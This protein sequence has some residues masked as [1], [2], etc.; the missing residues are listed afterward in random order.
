MAPARAGRVLG[1]GREGDRESPVLAALR[2]PFDAILT[3][4]ASAPQRAIPLGV[5]ALGVV[6]L[7]GFAAS[8]PTGEGIPTFRERDILINLDAAPGT[9]EGA[10]ARNRELMGA[11]NPQEAASRPS[12]PLRNAEKAGSAAGM[13]KSGRCC[14]ER[15]IRSVVNSAPGGRMAP[16]EPRW[17]RRN[18]STRLIPVLG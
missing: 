12:V 18:P 1:G 2:A 15:M 11:T 6:V 4:V 14:R 8:P 5:A 17:A 3:R 10:I 13:R 7:L 16:F 9:G